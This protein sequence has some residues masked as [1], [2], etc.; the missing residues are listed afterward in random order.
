MVQSAIAITLAFICGCTLTEIRSKSKVGPEFRYR[1]SDRTN[2]IRWYAQQGFDFV[3]QDDRNNKI[4]TGITYRR[5]DIDN[6]NSDNDNGVWLEFSFPLWVAPK[7]PDPVMQRVRQ[8]ERR[9]AE[10]EANQSAGGGQIPPEKRATSK[11]RGT[12]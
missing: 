2:S 4:T 9:L 12:N 11:S 10:L 1:S 5:R 3:W 8:L 6:G 7:E